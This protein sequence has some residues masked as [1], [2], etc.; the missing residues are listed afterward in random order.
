M[1]GFLRERSN[2]GHFFLGLIP[3]FSSSWYDHENVPTWNIGSDYMSMEK[4]KKDHQ[5]EAL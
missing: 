5:R 1:E 3:I 2:I 4:I